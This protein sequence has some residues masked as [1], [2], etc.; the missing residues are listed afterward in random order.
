MIIDRIYEYL[1]EEG[2][3][4]DQAI[5][6]EATQRFGEVL[7]RQLM[8]DR[9]ERPGQLYVT[10]FSHPCARKGAYAYHG[11]QAEKLQPRAKLTFLIGDAVEL[12][13]IATA[14]LAGCDLRT[15]RTRVELDVEGYRASGYA[16]GLLHHEGE[17]YVVE[18]KSMSPYSFRRFQKEG[19]DDAFGYVSK[20]QAYMAGLELE[21]AIVVGLDKQT[22][23]L[24]E[25]IVEFD[26][27][28][29][30]LAKFRALTI[31]GSTPEDL[32]PRAIPT[33]QTKDGRSI[34]GL[35]CGY[36]G[37]PAHC[38]P[39]A[40]LDTSGRKPV[41]YVSPEGRKG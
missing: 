32:P 11:Y 34:L 1:N 39:E 15:E 28:T 20:I 41:W 2:K 38:W 30:R 36:C 40:E 3:T 22:G 10:R 4:V 7:V 19:Y 35:Q 37:Y 23:A 12:A 33:E 18:I 27:E 26:L 9:E 5:L 17:I 13:V 25:E 29:W 21:R 14:K 6:N 8:I 24:H 16:D 31:L